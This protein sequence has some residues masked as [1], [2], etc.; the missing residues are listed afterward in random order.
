M[1]SKFWG[2]LRK[3][4]KVGI[5]NKLLII[6]L[7]PFVVFFLIRPYLKKNFKISDNSLAGRHPGLRTDKGEPDVDY[8]RKKI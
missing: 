1:T 6:F 8:S 7:F 2:Y 5:R 4:G 3:D